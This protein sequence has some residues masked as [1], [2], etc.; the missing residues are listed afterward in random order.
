MSTW[1]EK[2]MIQ[3]GWV[4]RCVSARSGRGSPWGDGW[5]EDGD[6]PR[7]DPSVCSIFFHSVYQTLIFAMIQK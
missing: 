3:R 7:Q 6:I 5:S 4:A 2:K 1:D